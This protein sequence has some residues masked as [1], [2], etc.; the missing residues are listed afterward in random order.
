MFLFECKNRTVLHVGDFRWNTTL[1]LSHDVLRA[2]STGQRQL[3]VL[4]LD[5]T[6][7]NAKYSLPTQ[8]DCINETIVTARHEVN[9]A[10]KAGQHILLLFGAYTIGKEAV[11]MA[12]AEQLNMKVYVDKRRYRILSALEWTSEQLSMF[13]T[14]PKETFLWVVPLGHVNMKKMAPYL[15]LKIP[16]S[17]SSSSGSS[18]DRVVGFRPTGW[19][20]KPTNP[21]T[22][23]GKKSVSS[24]LNPNKNH[25]KYLT[26][27]TRGPLT[28][29]S[30]PY[31]EHSSFPELVECVHY[32]Q[33]KRIIPT[34]SVSKSQEQIDLLLSHSRTMMM[35]R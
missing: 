8:Q 2:F 34:V 31:S 4:F 35:T 20:L 33:P 9:M 13:T 10:Q 23:N 5:T 3:D 22:T 29:H 26:T 27:M 1:M 12:V 7:C 25:N 14:C 17:G 28:V 19:S 16:G 21:D 6:Y 15:S 32:L 24:S 11:Y 30:V 18:Y